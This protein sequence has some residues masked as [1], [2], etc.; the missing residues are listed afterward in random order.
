M[1]S[2]SMQ[3]S[4]P[5]IFLRP[6]RRR[7][8]V[9]PS[10]SPDTRD[11]DLP[12][13]DPFSASEDEDEELPALQSVPV[14]ELT[15]D[16]DDS[17]DEDET[18]KRKRNQSSSPLSPA[19]A[20]SAPASPAGRNLF[21]FFSAALS[22]PLSDG[23]ASSSPMYTPRTERKL[24]KERVQMQRQE[25]IAG[26]KAAEDAEKAERKA[27]MEAQ[28]NREEQ[29]K[30]AYFESVLAGL[31]DRNYSLADFME[32][33]FNPATE[34]A[35]GFDWRWRG[36]FRHQTTVK[37]M[38]GHWSSRAATNTARTVIWD[39]AYDL[40]KRAVSRESRRITLSGLLSKVKRTV[41]EDFFL[42]YSLRGISGT[43]RGMAPAAF[44]IFDSFSSTKRQIKTQSKGFLKKR[45]V[46][47]GSAALALLNGAS[48]PSTYLM[49]TGGQRQHFSVL[50]GFGI[51]T[52]YTSVISRGNKPKDTP[53]TES[54]LLNDIDGVDDPRTPLPG[55]HAKKNK[56]RREALRAKKRRARAPGT[57]FLLSE[58]CRATARAVAATS[59]F[60]V[61]YDNINMMVRVAEQILG[62]K[63]PDEVHLSSQTSA[64]IARFGDMVV[65][66]RESE[67]SARCPDTICFVISVQICSIMA[68]HS[69]IIFNTFPTKAS[70]YLNLKQ[71]LRQ[72]AIDMVKAATI[73]WRI[74]SRIA[75]RDIRRRRNPGLVYN[76]MLHAAAAISAA[77]DLKKHQRRSWCKR[78]K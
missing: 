19:P 71:T 74:I 57:L 43:L 65:G 77:E 50:H 12:L 27:A 13:S 76:D 33:T 10:S 49:A 73:S 31:Q 58:A 24:L 4:S 25:T 30:R 72:A 5:P 41:N 70:T 20:S 16:E 35:S 44:G 62:R 28:K 3:E 66:S 40:V 6:A 26:K 42:S 56:R 9:Q 63:S 54:D 39:W 7:Y 48:C 8:I 69:D 46:L 75:W 2:P 47:A 38:L 36:F 21:P 59:L 23:P 15:D 37:K 78:L 55:R 64:S 1:S 67:G 60:L 45:E 51:T 68:F 29:E 32:Y 53:A 18:P 34:F 22:S 17:A 14:E 11:N 52:G 61:M